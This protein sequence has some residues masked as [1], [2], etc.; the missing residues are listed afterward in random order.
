MSIRAGKKFDQE[1]LDERA[2]NLDARGL[3]GIARVFVRLLP[4]AA[5][6]EAWLDI[7]FHTTHILAAILAAIGGGANAHS[8]FPISGGTRLRGGASAGQVRVNQVLAGLVPNQLRLRVGLIGDY[9][10]YTLS[11]NF[12]GIDPLLSEIDFKFR[13]ACF[14]MNCAGSDPFP[15]PAVVPDIDYLAKDFDSF[16]HTLICAMQQRVPNW[17]PTSEADMDQVLIDLIAADAD[18]LSDFQDRTLN[19]AFL[20]TARKRVSLARHARL[21]DYHIHQGNQASSWLAL[22]VQA[23]T[24]VPIRT[25]VWTNENWQD[26]GSQAF[27]TTSA[28]SCNPLLNSLQLY[29]WGGASRRDACCFNKNSTQRPARYSGA[30]QH[31]DNYSNWMHLPNRYLIRWVARLANGLCACIGAKQIVFRDVIASARNATPHCQKRTSV[32]FM[33]IWFKSAMAGRT[34]P[35]S[36]HQGQRWRSRHHIAFYTPMRRITNRPHGACSRRFLMHLWP[37][38]KPKLAE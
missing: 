3:N 15:A 4:A 7:E 11:I 12:A 36:G 2:R 27:V 21:M 16:K 31:R 18:E 9:S 1:V 32:F 30:I 13:P 33:A 28:V 38:S 24:V 35:C 20:A 5:P 29:T 17:Q 14:N 23:A 6:T 10:T 8:I 25:G 37:I 22:K 26:K 34:A 19:E